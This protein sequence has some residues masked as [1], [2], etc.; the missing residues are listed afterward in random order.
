MLVKYVKGDLVK[1]AKQGRFHAIAHG[2]NCFNVMGAGIAKQIAAAF[3]EAAEVDQMT[4][5]RSVTKLGTLTAAMTSDGIGNDLL[6]FN[7]YTQYAPGPHFNMEAL[8][9]AI[10]GM[11]TMLPR[12]AQPEG[13]QFDIG[14]PRIGAGIG[15]GDWTKIEPAILKA[16]T[17]SGV[18]S[19]N[20][21]TFVEYE[22]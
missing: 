12:M 15:G 6:V 18:N 10:L 17:L 13:S 21:I 1:M 14:L 3:P 8:K 2:C 22:P 19:I 9:S 20:S 7:L 4:Q 11:C 16:V 5:P